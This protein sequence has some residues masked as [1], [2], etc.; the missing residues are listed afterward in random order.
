MKA[1][2]YFMNA[3]IASIPG[4]LT[5]KIR[6]KDTREKQGKEQRMRMKKETKKQPQ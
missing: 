5:I 2:R 3:P 1:K 6:K 4:P